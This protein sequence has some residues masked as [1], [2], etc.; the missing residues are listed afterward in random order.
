MA[1]CIKLLLNLLLGDTNYKNTD[2]N[3]STM[4]HKHIAFCFLTK[5]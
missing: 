5:L 4:T 1:L 3:Y 2:L